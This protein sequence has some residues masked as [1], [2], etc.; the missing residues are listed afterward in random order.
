[1]ASAIETRATRKCDA[2]VGRRS[3]RSVGTYV[4]VRLT[5]LGPARPSGALGQS[6]KC[7]HGCRRASSEPNGEAVR[8][9]HVVAGRLYLRATVT[10]VGAHGV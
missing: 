3:P 6:P 5:A 9:G 10:E 2:E 4:D 8:T 1:M 7:L